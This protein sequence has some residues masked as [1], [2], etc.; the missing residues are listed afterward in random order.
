[1]HHIRLIGDDPELLKQV[2][3]DLK[4]TFELIPGVVSMMD[5]PDKEESPSEMALIVDRDKASSITCLVSM[6]REDKSRC[7]WSLRRKTVRNW[8]I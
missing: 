4:P 6:R 7:V 5:S 3:E 2:A 8:P 1:M